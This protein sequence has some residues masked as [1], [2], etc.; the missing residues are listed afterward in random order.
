VVAGAWFRMETCKE[1]WGLER[2]KAESR[3]LRVAC[4]RIRMLSG[5]ISYLGERLRVMCGSGDVGFCERF[6][7]CEVVCEARGLGFRG[8]R[9]WTT[10]SCVDGRSGCS[11]G[12]RCCY[13]RS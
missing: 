3:L 13:S 11:F 8:T 7:I 12:R 5:G 6:E 10:V 2:V 1:K 4:E 9:T